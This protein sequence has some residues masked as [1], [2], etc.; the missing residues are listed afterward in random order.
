M[1]ID[2]MKKYNQTIEYREKVMQKLF[3]SE[4]LAELCKNKPVD[5]EDIPDL[6]W[7]NYIPKLFIDG[8]LTRA[9][10]Y[11]LFDF[12]IYPKRV[13]TYNTVTMYIQVY[14]HKDVARLD[15][16][17]AVRQDAIIAEL[18]S[19]FDGK[20]ILGIGYNDKIV[21]KVIEPPNNKYVATQIVYKI[22][23]FNEKSVMRAKSH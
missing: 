12:D 21:E 5:E 4:T 10:A 6:A 22:A 1:T 9:E 11:I 19:M 18:N 15:N 20:N 2:E 14:C 7:E 16:G 23:D 13:D 8:T 17:L 3:E